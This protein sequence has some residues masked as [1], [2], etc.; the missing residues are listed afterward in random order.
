ME[1]NDESLWSRVA[2]I[3]SVAMWRLAKK[4]YVTT[5]TL[6][7]HK[8]DTVEGLLPSENAFHRRDA[9]VKGVE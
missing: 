1:V 7:L 4:R 5:R 2:N 8:L 3:C 9:L 6:A